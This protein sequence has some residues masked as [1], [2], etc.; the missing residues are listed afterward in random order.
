[1]IKPL[2]ES[3]DAAREMERFAYTVSHD[4]SAPARHIRQF[5]D[6]LRQRLENRLEPRDKEL[7]D[8]IEDSAIQ[9]EQMISALLTYSRICTDEKALRVLDLSMVVHAVLAGFS[10]RIEWDGAIVNTSK[11]PEVEADWNQLSYVFEQ[12]IDNALTFRDRTRPSIVNISGSVVGDHV[13][14][15][16]RDNGIGIPQEYS[17]R[18]FDFFYRVDPQNSFGLGVGLPT[19]RKI[20]QTHGGQMWMEPCSMGTVVKFTLPAV[21]G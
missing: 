18:V 7:A 14:V 2:N 15:E 4:L 3:Q 5:T 20:V 11:L 16:V 12:L 21:S 9:L 10:K 17:E 1:M 13:E 8:I 19:S 6:L